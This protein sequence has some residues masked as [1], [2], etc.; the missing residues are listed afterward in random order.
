MTS[1]IPSYMNYFFEPFKSVLIQ[2]VKNT[3]CKTLSFLLLMEKAEIN[4]SLVSNCFLEESVSKL[5]L[6]RG[7]LTAPPFHS[8]QINNI[9]EKKK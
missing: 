3:S 8:D 2:W 4:T 6:N 5:F 1:A 9:C 7:H